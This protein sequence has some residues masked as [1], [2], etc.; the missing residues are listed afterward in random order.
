MKTFVKFTGLTTPEAV[1]EVPVGGAAAFVVE[2]ANSPRTL[3]LPTVP[4]LIESLSKEA[5]AWAVTADPPAE[6]IHR[7]FDEVGVDRIQVYGKIPDGLEFLEIHH[8]V[9]SLPLPANGTT[10]P[11]PV[12]PP[13]ED[14]SRLHLDRIGAPL[15]DGSAVPVDW[16]M[17]S[18]IV[19]AQPG[20]KVILAGGLTAEN[21]ADALG[22]VRPWGLDV[23]SGV[24][25][26]PGVK[27]PSRMRAFLAAVEAFEKAHP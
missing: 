9:P 2:V 17:A 11:E 23:S 15:A 7:L 25:T 22:A 10:G 12:V 13:A 18:R 4:K 26:S 8:I 27:D 19:E 1:Q 14:Y 5:E 6:L 16:E 24:E 21:V 20:R 3:D